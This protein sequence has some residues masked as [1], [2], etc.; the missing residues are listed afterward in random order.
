MLGHC[1]WVRAVWS[2]IRVRQQ[3]LWQ[4][5]K[6]QGI[7]PPQVYMPNWVGDLHALSVPP[8]CTV[9]FGWHQG[10][11]AIGLGEEWLLIWSEKLL[12]FSCLVLMCVIPNPPPPPLQY[13]CIIHK[14]AEPT[15]SVNALVTHN[16][17][18]MQQSCSKANWLHMLWTVQQHRS[19]LWPN[20]GVVCWNTS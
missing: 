7:H 19:E 17:Q 10:Y 9:C 18:K 6:G 8:S 3:V 14:M 16:N 11:F 2:G 4:W 12:R 15:K 20:R 13:Y 1:R 5:P